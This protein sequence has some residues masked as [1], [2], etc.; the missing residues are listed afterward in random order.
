[1]YRPTINITDS[2]SLVK[3]G[4]VGMVDYDTGGGEELIVHPR[5]VQHL[6]NQNED[7]EENVTKY[8]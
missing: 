7:K 6:P 3:V 2:N 5:Y 1:M 8:K 4:K